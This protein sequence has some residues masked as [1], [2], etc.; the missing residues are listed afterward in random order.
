ME[1]ELEICKGEADGCYHDLKENVKYDA[2]DEEEALGEV[3]TLLLKPGRA[4]QLK[5]N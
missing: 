3:V 2:G 5:G 4:A 1:N